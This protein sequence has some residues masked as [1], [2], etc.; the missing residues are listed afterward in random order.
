MKKHLLGLFIAGFAFA[1]SFYISPIRFF[2]NGSGRGATSDLLYQ[3]SSSNNTSNHFSSVFR[4]NCD[5]ENPETADEIF[6][7]EI[8]NA[9]EIV[10]PVKEIE[11]ESGKIIRRAIIKS[12]HENLQIYCLLSTEGKWFDA[13]SSTSLRHVREFEKQRFKY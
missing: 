8:G 9:T 4:S 12:Y 2:D 6:K 7:N 11:L 1:F 13:V 5:Y 3:C 10:E